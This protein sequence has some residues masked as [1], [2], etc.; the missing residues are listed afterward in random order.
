[1][2][3]TLPVDHFIN[4]QIAYVD[5]HG[6]PAT[7][8]GDVAWASS[9]PAAL[10]VQVNAQDSTQCTVTPQGT[11]SSAQVV[12]TADADLG[13]GIR[14]IITTL[15]IT[16]VAGEAVAGTINVVGDPQPIP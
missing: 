9:N 15:D 8:D 3:Y 12:A 14:Q 4:V 1:M 2:A 5:G 6:N 7:V 11:L 16:L 10:V 13:A